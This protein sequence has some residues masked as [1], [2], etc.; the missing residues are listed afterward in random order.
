MHKNILS[1]FKTTD[2]IISWL[3]TYLDL[4]WL[5]SLDTLFSLSWLH[6]CCNTVFLA[7]TFIACI[8]FYWLN[9]SSKNFLIVGVSVGAS[10]GFFQ[11][12]NQGC[13]HCF[14]FGAYWVRERFLPSVAWLTPTFLP[15]RA[16]C[17][18]PVP[19]VSWGP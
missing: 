2:S 5:I 13:N 10:F 16:P 14:R 9:T 15:F 12:D 8:I 1:E 17:V 3:F 18:S 11:Y 6:S 7:P 4:S 19:S